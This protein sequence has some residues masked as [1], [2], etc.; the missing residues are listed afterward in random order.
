MET[1]RNFKQIYF[2]MVFWSQPPPQLCNSFLTVFEKT[3]FS[4]WSLSSAVIFGAV[5]LWSFLTI[6]LRVRRSL[7]DNFRFLP[8]ICFSKEVFPSFPNAV[9]T[10]ETVFLATPNNSAVFVTLAPAI[11][12][13]T[14]WPLL[15]SD[16]SAILMNFDKFLRRISI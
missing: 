7:S 15:K 14:I 3:G 5:F 6:S 12:A 8:E 10:F 4:W 11:R 2:S 1:H 16:R 13:P 9:I